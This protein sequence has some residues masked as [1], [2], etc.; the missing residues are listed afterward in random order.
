MTLYQRRYNLNGGKK[1]MAS[2]MQSVLIGFLYVIITV[3]RVKNISET[4]VYVTIIAVLVAGFIGRK[5]LFPYSGKCRSCGKK[6]KI[7]QILFIDSQ[8]CDQCEN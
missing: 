7:D 6:L 3:V 5:R 2:L 4:V 8:L 1:R